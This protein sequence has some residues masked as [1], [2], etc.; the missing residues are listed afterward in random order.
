MAKNYSFFS[1]YYVW[2][3]KASKIKYFVRKQI[4]QS[5]VF[6]TALLMILSI[7][8]FIFS[9]TFPMTSSN[10]E[11]LENAKSIVGYDGNSIFYKEH[12][13]KSSYPALI[14][15]HDVN[16][17]SAYYEELIKYY[18]NKGL[19][20]YVMDINGYGLSKKTFNN[21]VDFFYPVNDLEILINELSLGNNLYLAGI[22]MGA[23]IAAAFAI[24]YPSQVSKLVL[25]S[26]FT[27]LFIGGIPLPLNLIRK[28]AAFLGNLKNKG[29]HVGQIKIP[30]TAIDA[31]KL[32]SRDEFVY[33]YNNDPAIYHGDLP[34]AVVSILYESIVFVNDNAF[35]IKV[36]TLVLNGCDDVVPLE[37]MELYYNKLGTLDKKMIKYNNSRHNLLNDVESEIVLKDIYSWFVEGHI[38]DKSSQN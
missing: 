26:P 24:K 31:A 34:L 15:L 35:A 29:L 13:V 38:N 25:I 18:N 19:S 17:Y 7:P 12:R 9:G 8:D 28:T 3:S 4:K 11:F 37:S 1:V 20:V 10:R 14:F 5:L 23:N 32:S 22:G 30:M 6:F 36:P 16:D 33:R 2:S 27:G 21:Y